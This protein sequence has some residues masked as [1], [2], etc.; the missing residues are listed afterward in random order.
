MKAEIFSH[1]RSIG[2][3]ELQLGDQSMGC[4]YGIFSPSENYHKYIRNEVWK[5]SKLPDY[6]VWSK[7]HFNIRLENGYFLYAAGGITFVDSPDLPDETIQV[8]IAGLDRH[9][10][11]DFFLQQPPRPFMEEP[12]EA[13][14]IEQKIAFEKELDKELGLGS[15]SSIF[16]FLKVRKVKSILSDMEFSALARA[17]NDD[18]LFTAR[19]N[20]TEL[21]FALIHLTWKGKKEIE[22]FP[23]VD[24]YNSFDE[25]KFFKMYPDKIEW[26]D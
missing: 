4:V 24:F 19:K 25:F 15:S 1:T 18:V 13:I 16:N 2:F 17:S 3:A 11:E 10:I 5:F 8:D 22:G 9:V 21:Q 12:W 14:S 7:L 6:K 26:E 23:L 20:G